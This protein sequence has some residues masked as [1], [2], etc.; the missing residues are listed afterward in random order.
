MAPHWAMWSWRHRSTH[1]PAFGEV[2]AETVSET[3]QK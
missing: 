1:E 2:V 3:L